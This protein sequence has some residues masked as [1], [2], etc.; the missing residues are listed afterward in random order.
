MHGCTARPTR[1]VSNP[2]DHTTSPYRTDRGTSAK[3]QDRRG[4]SAQFHYGAPVPLP[5]NPVASAPPAPQHSEHSE[6]SGHA[7]HAQP[8]PTSATA[9]DG[10]G[11]SQRNM[12]HMAGPGAAHG[13][14]RTVRTCHT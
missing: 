14:R 8:H 13:V 2:D 10:R 1:T 11:D 6:H 9:Y 5:C 3:L 4:V 12:A 7:G